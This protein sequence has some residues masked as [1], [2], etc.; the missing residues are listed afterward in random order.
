MARIAN[1]SVFRAEAV[2]IDWNAL[3]RAQQEAGGHVGDA[4][5]RTRVSWACHGS[6][7]VPHGVFTVWY[8][9]PKAA[10]LVPSRNPVQSYGSQSLLTW[11]G[12]AGRVIVQGTV[13]DP[14]RPVTVKLC[15][16]APTPE[17]VV[18]ATS[19]TG[20]GTL[21]I[22]LRTSGATCALVDNLT[23]PVVSV[24]PLADI[25]NADDWTPY[26]LI[27]LPVD[28]PLGDYDGAKQG[29][30]AALTDP[31][32]AALD[33]LSRGAPP[34]GWFPVLPSGVIAPDWLTPDL[35]RMVAVLQA[36]LLP[37]LG[38]LYQPGLPEHDQSSITRPTIVPGPGE[39]TIGVGP[40]TQIDAA[41]WP[42]LAIPTQTD[43][44]LNLALGFGTAYPPMP[45]D[46]VIAVLPPP[47]FLVT[48]T[49]TAGPTI[50]VFGQ[51][52]GVG[53]AGEYAAYAPPVLHGATA[54]PLGLTAARY[55]LNA[56]TGIDQPWWENVRLTWPRPIVGAGW[57]RV[58]AQAYCRYPT[59]AGQAEPGCEKNDDWGGWRIGS[60]P[61]ADSAGRTSVIDPYA[62]IPLGSGGRHLGFGVAHDDIY[63]VWSPWV[64][65]HLD[66]TEPGAALPI[67]AN[68]ALTARYSGSASA[69]PAHLRVETM[70][71]WS[72]RTTTGVEL[73]AVLYP[74]VGPYS[75]TPPGVGPGVAPAG[76]R[77][78]SWSYTFAGDLPTGVGCTVTPLDQNG[79][80]ATQTVPPVPITPGT[81][82]GDPR[83]FRTDVDLAPLD[84][85]GTGRWGV[86]IWA[87]RATAVGPSPTGWVASD[88]DR[89]VIATAGSPV[90]VVPQVVILPGVPLGSMPDAAGSSH[91]RIAWG[92]PP[93][94]PVKNWVIWGTSE[95]NLRDALGL[96]AAASPIPGARLLELRGVLAARG[97]QAQRA[98][99]RV[100][101]VPE[102]PGSPRAADVPLAR[103]AS[104]LQLFV[105]TST[106]PTGTDSPFPTV[107]LDTQTQVFIAPRVVSPAPPLVRTAITETGVDVDLE[108]ASN[109]PVGGFR[110]YRTRVFDAARR[111]DSMGAPTLVP[112]AAVVDGGG[113]PLRDVRSG[114]PL[115]SASMTLATGA[116]WQPSYLRAVA[117]PDTSGVPEQAIRGL[118]SGESDI[119]TVATPPPGGPD[120]APLVVSD[121]TPDH[122]VLVA[123]TST[124]APDDTAWGAHRA[125]G[126]GVTTSDADLAALATVALAD[127][128][129]LGDGTPAP[130]T[131][132]TPGQAVL[133]RGPRSGGRTPLAVWFARADATADADVGLRLVDPLGRATV[134]RA[135]APG[136]PALPPPTLTLRGVSHPTPTT[137]RVTVT[138]SASATDV[139]PATLSASA[140]ARTIRGPRVRIYRGSAALPDIPATSAAV[141]Q[142]G[143]IGFGWRWLLRPFGVRR[144]RAWDVLIPAG[145]P[146]TITV[147]IIA[148][149]GQSA[150]ISTT[151]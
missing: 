23:S 5:P 69:C 98:F 62:E 139:P 41:P 20:N 148:G 24:Q 50:D 70:L 35:P 59:G 72:Q 83:R 151:V 85:T 32:S 118:L 93:N 81:G 2:M 115:Y 111:A 12:T 49:Y 71:E 37:Q 143:L 36:A 86:V 79:Y 33:R 66:T 51:V 16:G 31:T 107:G 6:L 39:T 74:M 123:R 145:A 56:P 90:P 3:G 129:T 46:V 124:S 87:R 44:Y 27:G 57:G 64:E 104:D 133:V 58:T 96:G 42:M 140:R 102:H 65:T 142:P 13:S 149:D 40:T 136:V 30:L 9:R 60:V 88:P 28:G 125:A 119:V 106:T 116:G 121:G 77:T 67:L 105:V 82:Q 138:T 47:E 54:S 45:S 29:M 112:A 94:A 130:A 91:V 110:L 34:L 22:D 53:P 80:D 4:P 141:A 52:I 89:W 63:G 7:G 75:P 147:T 43:A 131:L 144:I 73:T 55:S 14:G 8:R 11:T 150:S 117:V 26:E 109:V 122:L 15:W 78:A 1:P 84:F 127:V 103:G 134:Q 128:V 126:S 137:T 100:L 61:S 10:K 38:D 76:C 99:R 97:E 19:R 135:T 132:P 95:Q 21:S 108:V 101:E 25:V 17:S 113:E 120:L 48:A 92:A 68:P 18:A 114:A 146:L